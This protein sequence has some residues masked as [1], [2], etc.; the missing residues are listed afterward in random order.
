M[1]KSRRLKV[2]RIS[3][4]QNG[5]LGAVKVMWFGTFKRFKDLKS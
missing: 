3:K 5:N 2:E 1:M 4:N